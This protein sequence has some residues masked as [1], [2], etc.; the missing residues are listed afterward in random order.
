[1][2]KSRGYN[3]IFK[4]IIIEEGLGNEVTDFHTVIGK[5]I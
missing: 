1:M 5:Y 3:Q 2:R 4:K